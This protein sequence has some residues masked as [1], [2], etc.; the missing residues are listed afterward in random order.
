MKNLLQLSE[1]MVA[2]QSA[3]RSEQ[4]P[5]L[6]KLHQRMMLRAR[7]VQ[8]VIVTLSILGA[9]YT[10]QAGDQLDW[11]PFNP[12][13]LAVVFIA[14]GFTELGYRDVEKLVSKL[15]FFASDQL[16]AKRILSADDSY[17]VNP[18]SRI[19]PIWPALQYRKF[20][21]S[22][23]VLIAGLALTLLY[24]DHSTLTIT[25]SLFIF[26]AGGWGVY[27]QSK[28][29]INQKQAV[30]QDEEL[31]DKYYFLIPYRWNYIYDYPRLL[32]SA[33]FSPYQKKKIESLYSLA[34]LNHTSWFNA[35]RELCWYFWYDS[36]DDRRDERTLPYRIPSGELT[37][38]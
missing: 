19:H 34:F 10:S 28:V 30:E 5:L 9:W 16:L 26:C 6:S 3:I 21:E 32:A 4:V 29:L 7:S 17:S 15:P 8:V 38:N 25:L 36:D 27:K 37:I 14:I 23:A 12:I 20:L 2:R 11:I 31:S 24:D 18:P 22:S 13:Y 35:D 1:I 33:S